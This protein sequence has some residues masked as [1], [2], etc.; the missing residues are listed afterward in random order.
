MK[1]LHLSCMGPSELQVA[2]FEAKKP[3]IVSLHRPVIGFRL[4]RGKVHNFELRKLPQTV[5]NS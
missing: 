3:G 5:V 2:P 1:Q 4:P